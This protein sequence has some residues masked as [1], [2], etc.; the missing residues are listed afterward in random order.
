MKMA[1]LH[2]EF[3]KHK[4]RVRHIIVH[5][6]QHYDRNLSD[7]FFRQLE[8]P[9]PD[10]NLNAGSGSHAE[11]TA[12][13]M[14]KLEKIILKYKPD[15]VIVY[16]DV[17]STLASS[18]VC[19]KT[20]VNGN[21]VPVAHVEAGLRSFDLT[22]PEE[23]NRIV[24]DS[25]AEYLFVPEESGMKNLLKT[26]IS[27]NKIFFTGNIMIDSLKG[28]IKQ[29]AKSKILQHLTVSKKE[30][31]LVTLHRPSN[32]DTKKSILDII[33]I[34]KSINRISGTLDIV[35]PVHPRTFKMFENF[36]LNSAL[37][38][39][40][41]LILTEPIGYIEFLS[42]IHNSKFVITDSGGIQEET[43][44][45][46][47]PCLTIRENTERPVTITHGTNI[48]C[49]KDKSKI[50]KEVRNIINGKPKK[51]RRIKYYDGNTARRISD[52]ILNKILKLY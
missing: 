26:G 15:L 24:T 23:I 38:C 32:V 21:P 37:E 18:V 17:N 5:T 35:F 2:K 42:L 27:R 29:S 49:G 43:S 51:G 13:I 11:Q 3:S 40:Q 28:F 34:F 39:V 50:E 9:K 25:L 14:T 7:V 8:L 30:Y 44:Y 46:G 31:V 45:L 12:I 19:A 33:D 41:N 20:M 48:L 1:P 6:G 36:G 52:I 47:I 10:I 16:G 4:S 22:M